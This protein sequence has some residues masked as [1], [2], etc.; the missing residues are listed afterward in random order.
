MPTGW[1]RSH[2][3]S[4]WR[5]SRLF[6]PGM[7]LQLPHPVQIWCQKFFVRLQW[8]TGEHIFW[9]AREHCSGA[10]R[11]LPVWSRYASHQIGYRYD[12]EAMVMTWGTVSLWL[13]AKKMTGVPF[14]RNWEQGYRYD[15]RY[16]TLIVMT[17]DT[18]LDFD[19]HDEPNGKW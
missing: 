1:W 14:T 15:W 10:S 18:I 8:G 2:Y 16:A 11:S 17:G 3:S 19:I 4:S 7:R 13:V 9:K 5:H 6:P 12:W